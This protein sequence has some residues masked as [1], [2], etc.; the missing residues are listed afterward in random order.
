KLP[1][2]NLS[3]IRQPTVRVPSW[4]SLKPYAWS[5]LLSFVSLITG[6]I[7]TDNVSRIANAPVI[8]VERIAAVEYATLSSKLTHI[9]GVGEQILDELQSAA[10]GQREASS[11]ACT[12]KETGRAAGLPEIELALT[13][14]QCASTEMT[15]SRVYPS[16]VFA[17]S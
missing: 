9:E 2:I 7:A 14:E 15:A 13:G 12:E 17:I 4:T 1:R 6:G 16:F 11:Q 3:I 10:D 5:L 8:K